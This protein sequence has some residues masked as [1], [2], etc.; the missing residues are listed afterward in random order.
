MP[1]KSSD[2]MKGSV[3]NSYVLSTGLNLFE[4][5]YTVYTSPIVGGVML[6][7]GC[8]KTV[9]SSVLLTFNIRNSMHTILS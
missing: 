7:S 1:V 9:F 3:A 2:S 6:V 5:A 4:L 8:M